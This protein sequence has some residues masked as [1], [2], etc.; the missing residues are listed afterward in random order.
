[1][2]ESRMERHCVLLAACVTSLNS[3]NIAAQISFEKVYAYIL[4]PVVGK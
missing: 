3:L 1:M 2:A 4:V